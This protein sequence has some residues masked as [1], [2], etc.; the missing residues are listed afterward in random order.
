MNKNSATLAY[1]GKHY[2]LPVVNSTMGPDAVDVR[3]LYKDAGLFTYDP[4]LMSTAS[5]SSAITYIDGDKGEL[6]YRGYPI[7]QLATHCDYLETC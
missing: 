5:C 3:S 6:F 1:K 4:G 7:E 2:E